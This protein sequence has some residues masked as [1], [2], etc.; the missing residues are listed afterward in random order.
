MAK[1]RYVAWAILLSFCLL[2]GVS[3]FIHKLPDA[4]VKNKIAITYSFSGGRFGDNLIAFSHA[5]WLAYTMDL[6]FVYKPFP[7]SDRLRMGIDPDLKREEEL[8]NYEERRLLSAE[9]YLNFLTEVSQGSRDQKILYNLMY[10]SE[11]LHEY[12]H[13]GW[14]AQYIKV[15]WNDPGFKTF[16]QKMISPLTNVPQKPVDETRI[17]VALHVRKGGGFD[18]PLWELSS[19]LKGPPETYYEKALAILADLLKKPLYVFIFTDHQ[20]PREIQARFEQKFSGKDIVFNS[21][22]TPQDV[23]EDFFALGEFEYLICPDSSYSKMAAYLFPYKGVLFPAH[24]NRSW[25]GTVRID[26]IRIRLTPPF[27]PVKRP[28]EM[29]LRN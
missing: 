8:K 28:L 13:N 17:Q 11:S 21:D 1:S 12:D 27:G 5:A 6:G 7:Y 19:V 29:E 22:L 9:E 10:F 23:V 18:P 15:D 2:F 20:Q 25:N 24:Y 14:L 16:L 3:F 4:A 26:R